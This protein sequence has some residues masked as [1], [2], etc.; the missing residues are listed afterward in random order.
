MVKLNWL[1]RWHAYA[2]SRDGR[3]IGMVRCR[4]TVPFRQV[5][6]FA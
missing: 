4:S 1:P 6:E 3:I 2:V 5:V